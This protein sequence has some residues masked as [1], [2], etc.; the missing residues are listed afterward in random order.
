MWGTGSLRGPEGKG[1][2]L[3]SAVGSAN[4]AEAAR[5]EETGI[6][7]LGRATPNPERWSEME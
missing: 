7:L 1:Q 5:L 2:A 4:A 6:Q 3:S